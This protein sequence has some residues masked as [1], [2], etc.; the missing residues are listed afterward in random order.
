[1]SN[2]MHKFKFLW[3]GANLGGF[4]DKTTWWH[5]LP[6]FIIMV[7]AISALIAL[8]IQYFWNISIAPMFD[9][10]EIT[11]WQALCLVFLTKLLFGK[12]EKPKKEELS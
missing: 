6:L 1:M 9:I 5:I 8:I 4:S 11:W 3:F 2:K 7:V 10:K 12:F